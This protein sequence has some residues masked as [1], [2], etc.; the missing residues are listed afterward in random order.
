[1]LTFVVP[2]DIDRLPCCRD[3]QS[4]PLANDSGSV[5]GGRSASQH[6]HQDMQQALCTADASLMAHCMARLGLGLQ[7]LWHK[8][9]LLLMMAGGKEWLLSLVA[10]HMGKVVYE[11]GPHEVLRTAQ[12]V[13]P[14]YL[15]RHL[16]VLTVVRGQASW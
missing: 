3:D 10:W 11:H 13:M 8:P 2:P 14:N 16:A 1:M 7:E 15:M 6:L 4:V 5:A 12:V 9:M